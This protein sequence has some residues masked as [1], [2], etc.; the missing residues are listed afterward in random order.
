MQIKLLIISIKRIIKKGIDFDNT[1]ALFNVGFTIKNP[2][3]QH[4]Y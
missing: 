1:K 2:I 3:R 4:N